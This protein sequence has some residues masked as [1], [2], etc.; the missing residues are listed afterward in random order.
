[1]ARQRL[2]REMIF[3]WTPLHLLSDFSCVRLDDFLDFGVRGLPD[4]RSGWKQIFLW[5]LAS[6]AGV[7]SR[8][9]VKKRMVLFCGLDRRRRLNPDGGRRD[10]RLLLHH[11]S[12]CGFCNIFCGVVFRKIAHGHPVERSVDGD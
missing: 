7:N 4:F 11:G 5:R 12:V 3:G 8:R 1:M 6:G 9:L 2:E 10:L